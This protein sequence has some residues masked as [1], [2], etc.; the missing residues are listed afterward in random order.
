M[1]AC[2]PTA[3]PIRPFLD[4]PVVTDP[5]RWDADIAVIGIQHSE[6]YSG[7]PRPNDQARAP[8]AVRL[9][10]TQFSDGNDHWDFDLGTELAAVLPS[11]R[12]DCGNVAWADGDYA[13]YAGQVSDRL[14]LL[15]RRGAQVF[16]IGGDHGFRSSM[17]WT[18]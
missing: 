10:S 12:I 5:E 6:P 15:W 13:S 3:P 1:K 8:D 9:A 16:V 11:R 18:C 14:R 17:R 7:D 2:L 4:W